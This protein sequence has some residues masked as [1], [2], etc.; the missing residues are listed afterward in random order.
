MLK[1]KI[2]NQLI[3][4]KKNSK[5]KAL[6]VKGARQIGKTTVIREFGK[7]NYPHF[8]EI[9]FE[10][11]PLARKA[12][13]G[14]LDAATIILNLSA[15]GFGPFVKGETLVF[16]DEI[17]S[18][19]NARTAIKFLVEDGSYDYVES[20]SLLGINYKDVSSYPVGYERQISM[21]ALDF[22]EFLWASGVGED[23]VDA[24]RHCFAEAKPVPDFL[25]E[26]LMEH[27]RRYLIVGGMPEAV[28]AFIEGGDFT[29]VSDIQE[30]I[31]N[32]YRDD[33]AK[34]A[35]RQKTTAKAVFD[36]IP[37][38]LAKANKRFV[39][40]DI[41]KGASQRKY[42][43]ATEWLVDAGIAYYSYNV[44]ALEL[45]FSF[46]AKRNMYKLFLHDTGLLCRQSLNNLQFSV[47]NGEIAINEGQLTENFV[48]AELSKH[49]H[50]LFYYDRKSRLELDF[51]VESADGI[52]VIEVKSGANY[53]RHASLNTILEEPNHN[54]SRALVLSDY[55][56]EPAQMGVE[57]FPLYMAMLI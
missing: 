44:A 34:Y 51:L 50:D 23:V 41:E 19:P 38:Q 1:R 30:D 15:M 55:N 10:E 13:D 26:R 54:I 49:H 35:D 12:F 9:N 52:V 14:N 42:G 46:T 33:I 39:L 16:F 25:H 2:I 28:N 27:F 45:P 11:K 57:Y 20:G 18:C 3:E 29:N 36:A 43:D 22:E 53:K 8:V 6:L 24:L 4:W 37:S 21:Y 5:K 31:M 17:Q 7:H 48:A 40:A 56:V 32:S 47:L